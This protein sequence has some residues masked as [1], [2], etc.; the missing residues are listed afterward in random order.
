MKVIPFQVAD[1]VNSRIFAA[2][3]L[4]ICLQI[5]ASAQNLEQSINI[6]SSN[7]SF[8]G[9]LQHLTENYNLSFSYSPESVTDSQPITLPVETAF[10]NELLSEIAKQSQLEYKLIGGQIVF[11][12]PVLVDPSKT[13]FIT[14]IV[15]DSATHG[16]L[17]FANVYLNKSAVGTTTDLNGKFTLAN[18]PVGSCEII[19]SYVGF[20]PLVTKLD[21]NSGTGTNLKVKLSPSIKYLQTVTVR[22]RTD[23]EWQKNYEILLATL[24][25]DS[26]NRRLCKLLNPEILDFHETSK[27]LQVSASDLLVIENRALGYEIKLMIKDFFIE[28]EKYSLTYNSYFDSLKTTD[29][30]EFLRWQVNRLNAFKGSEMH[31][32]RAMYQKRSWQEGFIIYKQSNAQSNNLNEDGV[33]IP[34]GL[35]TVNESQSKEKQNEQVLF[36]KGRYLITYELRMTSQVDKL[37]YGMVHPTSILEITS[38]KLVGNASGLIV[39]PADY[40]RLGYME[41]QRFADKLPGNYNPN[42]S[43]TVIENYKNENIGFFKGIILDSASKQPIRNAEVFVNYSSIMSRSGTDGSFHFELPCGAY[44]LVIAKRDY[45]VRHFSIKAVAGKKT[46]DTFLLSKRRFFGIQKTTTQT[47][48]KLLNEFRKCLSPSQRVTNENLINIETIGENRISFFSYTPIEVVDKELGYRIWLYLEK[49]GKMVSNGKF[50]STSAAYFEELD[51]LFENKLIERKR[52][53]T[54]AGSFLNFTRVFYSNRMTEEGFVFSQSNSENPKTT[55]SA[56]IG[57]QVENSKFKIEYPRPNSVNNGVSFIT[58]PADA[59]HIP[60]YGI[61]SPEFYKFT[62]EGKMYRQSWTPELPLNYK[63][64]KEYPLNTF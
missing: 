1:V 60:S 61:L 10:L 36:S 5:P 13:G 4:V 7:W 57:K 24:L 30:K 43:E 54:Y 34:N 19:F 45:M 48:E 56:V 32:M 47:R 27:G 49:S 51:T 46:V 55:P 29:K 38:E 21:I 23:R 9:I 28:K 20:Q 6:K 14:G 25:G 26:E 41:N 40:Y 18:L 39:L 2:L 37:I 17:A 31:L 62:I 50:L 16:P 22:E 8:K 33:F 15:V 3:I 35:P 44:D 11:R 59:T 52:L 63:T 58:V 12:K 42:Y 64:P 53:E